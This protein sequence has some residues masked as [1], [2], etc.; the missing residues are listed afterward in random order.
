MKDLKMDKTMDTAPKER[1]FLSA[2]IRFYYK[3]AKFIVMR[4]NSTLL[5][6]QLLKVSRLCTHL[7]LELSHH[8][9]QQ[10]SFK[11]LSESKHLFH[12]NGT[13]HANETKIQ[14]F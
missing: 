4:I 5:Y 14:G 12:A 6:I 2:K 3:G 7:L 1:E 9:S 8:A 11:Q 10:L 13:V